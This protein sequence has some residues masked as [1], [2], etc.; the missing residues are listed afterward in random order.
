MTMAIAGI[1]AEGPTTITGAEA[2][3]IS[4]PMFWDTLN[5]LCG[6][7]DLRKNE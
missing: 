3:D 2:V 7:L 4:Y 5:I 6:S 1:M